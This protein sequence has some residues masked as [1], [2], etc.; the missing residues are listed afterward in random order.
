MN[1]NYNSLTESI[2]DI[3]GNDRWIT[4]KQHVFGGDINESYAVSLDDNTLLF[5]K[6]NRSSNA[7]ANFIAESR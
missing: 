7:P 5:L 3:F 1:M 6:T 2:R 4:G